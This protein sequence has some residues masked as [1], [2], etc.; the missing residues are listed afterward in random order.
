M[1]YISLV[2]LILDNP[3]VPELIQSDL[4][5]SKLKDV[6]GKINSGELRN[7]QLAGYDAIIEKLSGEKASQN[8]AQI[9]L[10]ELT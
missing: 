4:N 1:A 7:V 3:V 8:A 10:S 6:L 9:I 2:N 5:P